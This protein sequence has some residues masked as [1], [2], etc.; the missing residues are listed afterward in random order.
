MAFVLVVDV[1]LPALFIFGPLWSNIW[2]VFG[3]RLVGFWKDRLHM[4][5]LNG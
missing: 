2:S 1:F 4:I 5:G 3:R